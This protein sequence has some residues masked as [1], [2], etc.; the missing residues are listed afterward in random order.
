LW[1]FLVFV[2]INDGEDMVKLLLI[3]ITLLV[4]SACTD[5]SAL[6]QASIARQKGASPKIM[7]TSVISMGRDDD[8]GKA[9]KWHIGG[10]LDKK[11]E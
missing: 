1:Y 6:V 11:A 2:V 10:R 7:S 4:L 3:N 8:D 5:H 9:K